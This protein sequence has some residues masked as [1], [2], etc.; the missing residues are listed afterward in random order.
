MRITLA[1]ESVMLS[2][3]QGFRCLP[4]TRGLETGSPPKP[5][6]KT[7]SS[8]AEMDALSLGGRINN[9]NMCQLLD[10]FRRSVLRISFPSATNI[11]AWNS[12]HHKA[13]GRSA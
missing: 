1:T 3:L 5:E 7:T 9:Q 2:A 4:Y 12:D 11:L 8:Y 6:C 13:N 10:T